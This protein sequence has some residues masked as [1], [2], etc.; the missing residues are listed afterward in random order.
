MGQELQFTTAK[1][2]IGKVLFVVFLML[3]TPLAALLIW[4]TMYNLEG[5]VTALFREIIDMGPLHTL[6]AAW[7]NHFWGSAF[8]W[9]LL[10]V[11][12][13]AQVLMMAVLP[14][15][16]YQGPITPMGNVPEYRD[17][18]LLSYGI[19][20]AL[21]VG[22][23]LG[24]PGEG[25]LSLS[26]YQHFGEIL[27]ALNVFALAFCLLLYFKGRFAP[28]STD[29]STSG[30]F[31]FDFY[32]GTELYPRILGIDVKMFT[33]CRVGMTGWALSAMAFAFAQKE[34]LGSFDPGVVVTAA[35]LVMYLMKFFIWEPGYMRST[36][37]IT[38]RAGYYICW[39]CLVWVP[40]V[41]SSPAFFMV[42]HAGIMPMWVAVL[43]FVAG[44]VAI[45]MN[46]W[47][48]HQRMA[49]RAAGGN[50]KIWGK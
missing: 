26:I 4:H 44:T 5:S 14:G 47:A 45:W 50:V 25:S 31:L 30:N 8:A 3:S 11:F 23:E 39:G 43:V 7:L 22:L 32:W 17:N 38:D 41:Y 46:Y 33:N 1:P 37:I 27:A 13:A 12:M 35:L 21:F 34:L 19:S 20:I 28:S 18:G 42:G 9:K 24:W 15:K 48:D 10:A 29:A 2:G 36:D 16:A 49:F 6:Q 40:A